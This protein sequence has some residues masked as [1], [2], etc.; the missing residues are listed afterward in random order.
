ML[1][2]KQVA[3]MDRG[4]DAGMSTCVECG[5]TYDGA[6]LWCEPCDREARAWIAREAG[7]EAQGARREVCWPNVIAM[8]LAMLWPVGL[9]WLVAK[10]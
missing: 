9:V 10:L 3:H 7:F 4:E 8:C 5:K 2:V 6:G 1:R